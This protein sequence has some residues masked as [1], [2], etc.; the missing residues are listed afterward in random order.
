MST[1]LRLG[2][3]AVAGTVVLFS[4]VFILGSVGHAAEIRV[5]SRI[6][7]V[8][9]YPSGATVTRLA[10]VELP[11]GQHRL[12]IGGLTDRLDPNSLRVEG[13]ASATLSIGAVESRLIPQPVGPGTSTE[14]D[15]RLQVL[16][17]DRE[18]V[19][20]LVDAVAVK[21]AHIQKFAES[22][23]DRASGKD[24]L[25]VAQWPEAW[26]AVGQA[27]IGVT[28][29]LR[30]AR[31]A[32]RKVDEEIAALSRGRQSGTAV[33]AARREVSL[34]V[35][36]P[37]SV[38]ARLTLSYQVPGAEWRA[39][40]DAR[41]STGGTADKVT[42]ALVRRA[43]VSQRSG[44]DWTDVSIAVSTVQ[45][46]RGTAAPDLPAQRATF[47]EPPRPVLLPRSETRGQAPPART[48][49]AP[50]Q[51]DLATAPA[52]TEPVRQQL[53][54]LEAG[55]F[56]SQFQLPGRL[57]VPGDGIAKDFRVASR[58][59]TP[60]L[61]VKAVPSVEPAGF[62]EA[63]LTNEDEA[64]LL[65]GTVALFR[66]AVFVGSG[67]LELVAPG[68][69][70]ELGFGY[71]DRIKVQR[72]PVRR[73]ETEPGWIGSSRTDLREFRT[74]VRNLHP[75]PV[76]ISVIDQI[77][78]SENGAITVEPIASTTPPTEPAVRDRRGVMAWTYEYRPGE[79]REIRIGYRL[80]W[81]ADRRIVLEP[82]PRQ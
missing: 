8:T 19:A 58:E 5:P 72:L 33:D 44:E 17:D 28:E 53:A 35:E 16:R 29:E 65:P 42:L 27:M 15:R 23:P 59:V 80:R 41:L 21:K 64:P 14:V 74:V 25:P 20:G 39:A 4:A 77:P 2:H 49:E 67:R 22:G 66:D 24:A 10:E 1:G 26:E 62:L 75:F 6:D 61:L 70:F 55:A 60:T 18:R 47:Y 79:E 57:T 43:I 31:V 63:R 69:T 34:A 82:E 12:L 9:V 37:A 46:N 68:D 50:E 7:G 48:L 78:F 36:V 51:A 73:R 3:E 56:H 13:A 81:P 40:Y 76:R 32:L 38:R 54:E 11:A 71:D 45:P 30:A 52:L